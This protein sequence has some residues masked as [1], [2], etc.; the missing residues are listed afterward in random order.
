MS[1]VYETLFIQA[2]VVF[3]LRGKSTVLQSSLALA[4]PKSMRSVTWCGQ[5]LG[6]ILGGHAWCHQTHSRTFIHVLIQEVINLREY[7][8]SGGS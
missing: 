1:G 8:A 3:L 7:N 6:R 5:R 4:L 2:C